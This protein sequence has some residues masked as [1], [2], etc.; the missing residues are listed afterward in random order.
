MLFSWTYLW[1]KQNVKKYS[2]S[3]F[4]C[5]KTVDSVLFERPNEMKIHCTLL[6]ISWFVIFFSHS[7]LASSIDAM[8]KTYSWIR[9][10]FWIRWR[11]MYLLN[12][13]S[14]WRR[15]HRIVTFSIIEL[16]CSSARNPLSLVNSRREKK[17]SEGKWKKDEQR[18]QWKFTLYYDMEEIK[19]FVIFQTREIEGKF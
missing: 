15:I 2:L 14:S 1:S 12:T 7:S 6:S 5:T 11:W 19:I 3:V 18:K 17:A 10:R 13:E 8:M 4:I 9:K 16:L